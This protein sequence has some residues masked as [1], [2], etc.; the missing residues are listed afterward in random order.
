[1]SAHWQHVFWDMGGTMVDTYPALDEALADVV[2]RTG[3][4]V[5]VD[6]IARLTR[7]S[8]GEAMASLSQQFGI[9]IDEFRAAEATLKQRWLTAPPPKMDHLDAAMGRV[10]GL[11]LVVTHRDRASAEAL[12]S[13]LN[14]EVDDLICTSDGFPRKPDPAMYAELLTRHG[15]DPAECVGIGD[16]P[17]D[18]ASAKG[19]GIAAVMLATPGIEM[20]HD[21]DAQVESLT[22]FSAL[23][24]S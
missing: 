11:N 22:E 16:R 17:L 6:G 20:E 3:T 2:R 5:D 12:L 4:S 23:L 14:I 9:P 19:A 1:M 13:A 24:D 8:T 15:L 21:A 7:Q 10:P 18:A